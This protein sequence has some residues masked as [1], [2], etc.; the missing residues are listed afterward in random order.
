MSRANT[1][2]PHLDDVVLQ[3]LDLHA[4][5]VIPAM[6]LPKARRRLIVASGNALPTGRILFAEECAVFASESQYG[7][8]LEREPDIDHAVVIS[9]SGTKHAPRIIGDLIR[10]GL[11]PYLITCEPHS[12][13]AALIDAACVLATRSLPEPLTYNTST[14]LGMMLAKT[15]EEPAGIK[16]FILDEV[17]PRL[18]DL[19]PYRAFYL[20]LRSQFEVQQPMFVT[21]FDE[22]FGGRLAGRCYT[23]DQ[24][25]HG[26]TVVSWEKELFIAF[27]CE[28]EDFGNARLA[29]PL[30]HEA[31][32]AQMM[33]V[34]Y[35]V[36]GRIQASKPAWFKEHVASYALQQQRLFQKRG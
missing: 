15:R 30:P 5:Y 20:M 6:R 1:R 3:A 17:A 36:I 34:G 29:V 28:N 9:A 18:P 33:A 32:F 11:K 22:L 8:L 2:I 4:S 14:Y 23:V 26:K 12:P 25:M 10:R 19:A 27:G 21:K 35:Y 13:A 7:R 24:T 16:R 31:G